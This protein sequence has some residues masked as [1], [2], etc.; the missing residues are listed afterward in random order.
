MSLPVNDLPT[1]VL[2]KLSV[3]INFGRNCFDFKEVVSEYFNK[4]HTAKNL[5]KDLSKYQV[6]MLSLISRDLT[7]SSIFAS[8][9]RIDG[10]V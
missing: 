10:M 1:L 8:L 5:D 3:I 4:L 2:T 7:L 9:C 6:K